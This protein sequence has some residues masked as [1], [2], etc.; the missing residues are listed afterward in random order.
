[1]ARLV[2]ETVHVTVEVSLSLEGLLDLSYGADASYGTNV[3][4]K[5]EAIDI[6]EGADEP[7]EI[8]AAVIALLEVLELDRTWFE[9][10]DRGLLDFTVWAAGQMVDEKE[11]KNVDLR[12]LA[13]S[14]VPAAVASVMPL[15]T[16]ETIVAVQN[17]ILNG[18]TLSVDISPV[19][20]GN[21]A[22][23]TEA[24]TAGELPISISVMHSP[25]EM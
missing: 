12:M 1:L 17:F 19:T 6:D 18:G 10:R 23:M 24:F 3:L 8:L 14:A 7:A 20:T 13:A 21:A 9:L 22:R 2:D 5:V 16:P 4:E 25:R 11:M 15:D